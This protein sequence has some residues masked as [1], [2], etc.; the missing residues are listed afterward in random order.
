[1]VLVQLCVLCAL[2]LIG[3]AFRSAGH[4]LVWYDEVASILLAWLTY[5]GAALAAV[6]RAHIG[7]PGFVR[8]L[9]PGP[10]RVLLVV[11]EF[12]VIGF[13]VV[14]TWVGWQVFQV[15][16]GD[17]LVSLPE[18]PTQIA[19]SV[20]PIGAVLFIVAEVLSFPV[21]WREAS[22]TKQPAGTAEPSLATEALTASTE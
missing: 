8:S 12:L 5:Y 15:L 17:T 20:I 1:V 3:V 18:V 11:A 7:S 13:F 22:V 6:K 10:R 9:Q 4:A 14:V 2:V 21:S 19:Q 16:E